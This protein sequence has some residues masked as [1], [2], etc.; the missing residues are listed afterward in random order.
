MIL[1][2]YDGKNIRECELKVEVIPV[3][4]S[5]IMDE[6]VK[7]ANLLGKRFSYVSSYKSRPEFQKIQME[8]EKEDFD[9]STNIEMKY[10]SPITEDELNQIL[11]QSKDSTPGNDG[12]CYS[13]IKNLN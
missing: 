8:K 10:N 13:M 2:R 4:E 12:I 6:P 3:Q 7:I 9:F 1:D 11:Q 5:K